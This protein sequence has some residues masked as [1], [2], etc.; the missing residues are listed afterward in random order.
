MKPKTAGL[1]LNNMDKET[2]ATLST[3]FSKLDAE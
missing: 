2:A 3:S 1:V